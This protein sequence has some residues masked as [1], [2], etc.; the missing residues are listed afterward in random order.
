MKVI[1]KSVLAIICVAVI[2]F[3]ISPLCNADLQQSDTKEITQYKLTDKTLTQY[4]QATKNLIPVVQKNPKLQGKSEDSEEADSLNQLVQEFDA[5]PGAKKAL[6]DASLATRE[7]LTFHFAL[8]YAA[9]GD[10]I[11]K[12]GGQLPGEYSKA[13]VEFYRAHEAEFKKHEE[14]FKIIS[15]FTNGESG[16]E[17]DEND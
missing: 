1:E 8:I 4:F 10:I 15:K 2:T 3:F 13:N 9:S 12:S 5:I 17:E 7:Y 14:D 16:G 6:E 11:L